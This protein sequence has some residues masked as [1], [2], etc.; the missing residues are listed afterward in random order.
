MIPS[1]NPMIYGTKYIILIVSLFLCRG[2][3]LFAHYLQTEMTPTVEYLI[4]I[5][6]DGLPSGI[7]GV[8]AIYLIN[9][10]RR[11]DRLTHMNHLLSQHNLHANRVSACD[12]EQLSD[13]MI[14]TLV[15]PYTKSCLLR[16][17]PGVTGCLLSHI[18]VLYDAYKRNY[19]SVW[20]LEDDIEVVGDL[21]QI[22]QL[23]Q[24][25]SVIDPDW[26]VFYTDP[27]FRKDTTK[28]LFPRT[29]RAVRPDQPSFQIELVN[30][31]IGQVGS[32][33]DRVFFRWGTHSMI[34]SK[35]GIDK[36]VDYYLHTYLYSPIDVDIHV[37]PG[38]RE[39]SAITPIVTN[40]LSFASDIRKRKKTNLNRQKLDKEPMSI[41]PFASCDSFIAITIPKSGTH[42]LEKLLGQLTNKKYAVTWPRLSKALWGECWVL[43]N[44][45]FERLTE[46]SKTSY[47]LTHL[48]YKEEYVTVMIAKNCRGLFLYRDPRD[49]I[50][51]AYFYLKEHP[52]WP[53][54][55]FAKEMSD[56]IFEMIDQK[57]ISDPF[58]PT[59]GISDF[60]AQYTLWMSVPGIYSMRFEDLVGAE[61]G[62]STERQERVIADI[63][64][65]LGVVLT[66]GELSSIASSLYGE[67]LT[68]R[69][70]KIGSWR[71]YFDEQH[72]KAFK[73]TAGQLLI[74]LGYEKDFDW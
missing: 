44:W 14:S 39:Y 52:M 50:I 59:Q 15:G 18:S 1:K 42:L 30:R 27:D 19:H 12:G 22:P 16:F 40:G 11:V 34:I 62:G 43:P 9:L 2:V 71:D 53:P 45:K 24:Q 4:P 61:G 5:A 48:M 3:A 68:F 17:H 74:D 66:G 55:F 13:A 10:D 31:K 7:D 35:R 41:G 69:A 47:L 6:C 64:S 60:Y 36:I 67:S 29:K 72:K 37:I 57:E 8:E 25:L 46:P 28:Y 26:D 58:R 56:F 21:K 49:Q 20:V 65:H 73:K 32:S 51:S 70:G 54:Q 23:L 33:V 63:A 38:I